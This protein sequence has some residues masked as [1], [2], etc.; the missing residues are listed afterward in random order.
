V[1]N[2]LILEIY[3]EHEAIKEEINRLPEIGKVIEIEERDTS[4][5]RGARK[6][7]T[8]IYRVESIMNS[9]KLVSLKQIKTNLTTSFSFFDLISN[10]AIKWQEIDMN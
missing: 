8:K 9:N 7:T 10:P 4:G 6:A 1:N 5:K 2:K 3:N